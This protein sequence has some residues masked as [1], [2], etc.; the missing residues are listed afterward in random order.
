[1]EKLLI[2]V[3]VV[4]A[5]SIFL[6][7]LLKSEKVDYRIYECEPTLLS[8]SSLSYDAQTKNLTVFISVNCC[9]IDLRVEKEGKTYKIV[10][11]KVGDLCRC[12]CTK[13]IEI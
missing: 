1:M 6:L 11:R 5:V 13:K 7:I 2:L 10:E 9:G 3:F 12:F 4:I 8:K